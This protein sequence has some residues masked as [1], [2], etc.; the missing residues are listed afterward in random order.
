MHLNLKSDKVMN[1]ADAVTQ[2][3]Q[4]IHNYQN[5]SCN[6]QKMKP[7]KLIFMDVNMPIMDGLHATKKIREI[8]EEYQIGDY[9]SYIVA[10]TAYATDV[11]SKKCLDSG[12]ND[13]LTKPI[14]S[15]QLL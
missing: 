3:E 15:N 2:I 9:S 10:L 14:N 7:Y 5:R 11:F 1:G 6:C 4:R 13:S 8:E 12:M